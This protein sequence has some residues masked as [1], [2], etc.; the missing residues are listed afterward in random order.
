MWNHR[1][2]YRLGDSLQAVDVDKVARHLNSID[3][4]DDL[5]RLIRG[6]ESRYVRVRLNHP[7]TNPDTAP[8][9]G[10]VELSTG[11]TGKNRT[12]TVDVRKARS[13]PELVY[14]LPEAIEPQ[15]TGWALP[16]WPG[17]IVE[18][19]TGNNAISI[20]QLAGTKTVLRNNTPVG[21]L[22]GDY[23]A[24]IGSENKFLKC[25]VRRD[26]TTGTAHY[27]AVYPRQTC[28]NEYW[29]YTQGPPT[30][31]QMV[32]RLKIYDNDGVL[33]TADLVFPASMTAVDV[34]NVLETH[35]A[36]G[37]DTVV[38]DGGVTLPAGSL[39]IHFPRPITEISIVS[40]A[41]TS[42]GTI[43]PTYYWESC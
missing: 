27:V 42:G 43:Y 25:I 22:D 18:V 17:D 21:T 9:F 32:F 36:L 5:G 26:S 11:A 35:P 24:N 28:F 41:F 39:H 10:L 13:S 30:S 4:G 34:K 37:A 40:I 1:E 2:G 38:V 12:D 29:L 23:E 16:L 8:A 15:G 7:T 19:K 31:G 3:S 20:G 14:W 6:Q 33:Q